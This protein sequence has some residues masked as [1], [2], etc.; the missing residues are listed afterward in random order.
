MTINFPD[1]FLNAVR[2]NKKVDVVDVV[3]ANFMTD[4]FVMIIKKDKGHIHK[5]F[6]VNCFNFL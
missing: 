6:Y 3:K 1:G 2:N 4:W 5:T